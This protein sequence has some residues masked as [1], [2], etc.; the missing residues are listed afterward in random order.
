MSDPN[1]SSP[2]QNGAGHE[3]T[4]VSASYIGLFALALVV[5]IAII[6]P[7]LRW[8]FWRLEA[9]AERADKVPSPLA[10]DQEPPAP[11]LQDDPSADLAS[12]RAEEAAR[13]AT[14]GWID[15]DKRQVR[16]PVERAIDILAER[17]IPEPEGPPDTGEG[18]PVENKEPAP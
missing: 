7:L 1:Q 2:E 5:M 15:R 4:D 18:Q 6:L 16:V 14:Y 13:L 12:L 11:R 9:G 17:G 3:T 8:M 10:A